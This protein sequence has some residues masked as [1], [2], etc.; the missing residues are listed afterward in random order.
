MLFPQ[1]FLPVWIIFC[2]FRQ[3]WNCR[4]QTLSVWKSLKFVVW[5]RVKDQTAG[6]LQSDFNWHFPWKTISVS[7]LK[8]KIILFLIIWCIW[9]ADKRVL[10]TTLCRNG[11][12]CRKKP[13]V[14]SFSTMLSVIL[15]KIDVVWIF[16]HL[17]SASTLELVKIFHPCLYPSMSYVVDLSLMAEKFRGFDNMK[18]LTKVQVNQNAICL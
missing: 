11:R 7:D 14:S 9:E 16:F 12:K 2:H 1:C 13:A 15:K 3:I 18:D 4:L 5:E 8:V 6:L 10:K 17:L